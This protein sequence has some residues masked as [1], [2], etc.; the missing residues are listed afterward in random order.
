MDNWIMKARLI[1]SMAENDPINVA[2]GMLECR[3]AMYSVVKVV[4][5]QL[6]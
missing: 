1:A 3:E 2:N 5:M 4:Y 6:I